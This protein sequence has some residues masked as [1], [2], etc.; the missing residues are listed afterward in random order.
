MER[1]VEPLDKYLDENIPESGLQADGAQAKRI[2]QSIAEV[3]LDVLNRAFEDMKECT[4]PRHIY[5]ELRR[6]VLVRP[7]DEGEAPA[8]PQGGAGA[9]G[10]DSA[11][12]LP[13]FTPMQQAAAQ[14]KPTFGWATGDWKRCTWRESSTRAAVDTYRSLVL[15][16]L[17]GAEQASVS[18][19]VDEV[20]KQMDGWD[21]RRPTDDD[22]DGVHAMVKRLY[23]RYRGLNAPKGASGA[24]AQAVERAGEEE[25]M[26][27]TFRAAADAANKLE[28]LSLAGGWGAA[29]GANIKGSL[30]YF[31]GMRGAGGARYADAGRGSRG[32]RQYNKSVRCWQCGNQGHP[33]RLCTSRDNPADAGGGKRDKTNNPGRGGRGAADGDGQ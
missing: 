13:P 1:L 25:T 7:R 8:S 28:M 33:Q 22:V 18:V 3:V 10:T 2:R 32:G 23:A 30:N 6:K 21:G 26:D 17:P 9:S 20:A 16:K 31:R 4:V 14:R 19:M 15:N 27:T 5:D 12:K 29:A 11:R 24:I